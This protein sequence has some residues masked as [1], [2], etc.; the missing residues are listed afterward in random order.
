[1]AGILFIMTRAQNEI[2]DFLAAGVTSA[3]IVA[4]KASTKTKRRVA[5]LIAKEKT[6]GLL[7][8]EQRELDEYSQ[9]EHLLRLAKAKAR[10]IT[11]P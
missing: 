8:E 1:L 10:Q 2:I 9:L 11:Q 4:F 6:D 7:P 3:E 5:R